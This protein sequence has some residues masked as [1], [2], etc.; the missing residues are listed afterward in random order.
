M[1]TAHL[2]DAIAH[3]LTTP[4]GAVWTSYFDEGVYADSGLNTRGL[5]RFGPDLSPQWLYPHPDEAGLPFI[6]DC[7][8]LNIDGEKA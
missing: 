3:L 6:D 1:H 4:S 8:A 2:G 7:Y 5:V